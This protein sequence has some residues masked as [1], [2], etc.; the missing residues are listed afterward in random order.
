MTEPKRPLVALLISPDQKMRYEILEGSVK[1]SVREGYRTGYDAGRP[2]MLCCQR[3]PWCVMADIANS[4]FCRLIDVTEEERQTGGLASRNQLLEWMQRFYPTMTW[5]SDV[6]VVRWK[7]VRGK[8][9]DD[10]AKL[11][12]SGWVLQSNVRESSF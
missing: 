4:R 11:R 6:T 8:L 1:L 5:E 2:V 10:W 12:K 9:V 3:E 7:N